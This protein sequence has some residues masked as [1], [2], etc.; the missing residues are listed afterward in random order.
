MDVVR[1]VL[2]IL[3]G[4]VAYRVY[5]ELSGAL[6]GPPDGTE[7]TSGEK[8]GKAEPPVAASPAVKRKLKENEVLIEYCTS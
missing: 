2:V 1:A 6:V 4:L 3:A 5:R 8:Q 7:E